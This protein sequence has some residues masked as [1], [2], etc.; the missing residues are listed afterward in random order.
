MSAAKWVLELAVVRI[1]GDGGRARVRSSD[2]GSF[3]DEAAALEAFAAC[4]VDVR[5]EAPPYR[6]RVASGGWPNLCPVCGAALHHD[7]ATGDSGCA[8]GHRWTSASLL[9][10]ADRSGG[11]S[12]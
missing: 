12:G 2:H 9:V 11:V 1:D 3:A 6:G 8:N 4:R 10:A 5:A 7:P